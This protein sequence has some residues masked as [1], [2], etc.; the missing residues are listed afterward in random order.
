MIQHTSGI[1]DVPESDIL[2]R[3]VKKTETCWLWC[4]ST[5]TAGYGNLRVG[6]GWDYAHRVFYRKLVGPIPDDLVIDH[7]CRNRACVNPAH[8]EAVTHAEN[9]RRG[10]GPYWAVRG[11]CKHGHDI[12]DMANVYTSPRGDHRCRTCARIAEEKRRGRRLRGAKKEMSA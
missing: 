8:L 7:L 1:H 2:M 12:T 5:T 4:G 9:V 10:A 3:R 6:A 11:T